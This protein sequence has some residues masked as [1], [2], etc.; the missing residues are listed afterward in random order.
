M[1]QAQTQALVTLLSN[2]QADTSLFPQIYSDVMTVIEAGDQHW[3]TNAVSINFTEGS[4]N[5]TLPAALLDVISI[6]YDDTVLSQLTL[7]EL[8][9]L[10][11]GWRQPTG[12][13]VA[14]TVEALT[15]KT[16]QVSPSPS[17]ANT[18]LSIHSELRTNELPY[19]TLPIALLC[20]AR[21]YIRESPH[22]DATMAQLCAALGNLL[23]EMLK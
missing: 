13:P 2:G 14:Y 1:S 21:E 9:A 18:G 15:A 8:E 19:L 10:R 23:L 22:M 5:V 7:R 20:L 12:A 4:P 3:H 16:I 11:S 6:I 17:Y